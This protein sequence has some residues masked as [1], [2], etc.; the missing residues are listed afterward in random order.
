MISALLTKAFLSA[1]IGSP[2]AYTLNLGVLPTFSELIDENIFLASFLIII[3]FIIASAIRMT[4]IDYVYEKYRVN[5][6]PLYHIK[7]RMIEKV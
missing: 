5:L 4:I 7:K 1:I 3:P 6:D 2:I